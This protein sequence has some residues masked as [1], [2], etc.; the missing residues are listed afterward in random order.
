MIVA[1]AGHVDHGKTTLVRALTGVDT[2]RLPEE[3]ARGMSIDLG[4]A[5]ADLGGDGTGRLRRRARPR[6]LPP[7]HAGR[8]GRPSTS[9][10]WWSRPTTASMPQTREHLAILDL[11]GVRARRRG[12]DQDRPGRGCARARRYTRHRGAAGADRPARRADRSGVAH[13]RRRHRCAARG[14]WARRSRAGGRAPQQGNFRLAV[15][16]SFTLPGAGLVVT[17]AVLSGRRRVGDACCCRRPAPR[18]GCAASM[19]RTGRSEQAEAGMR[20]ALNLAG[21]PE[22]RRGRARRLGRRRR[23]ACAD[24][25]A[26]TSAAPAGGRRAGRWRTGRRC[27]C[28]WAPPTW[29]PTSR[30]CRT[31]RWRRGRGATRNWCSSGR[32]ARCTATASC[33]A[34]RRA[35]A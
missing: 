11:L 3:K 9:R 12:A 25:R 15:D 24:A 8:R 10:C 4:F 19:R 6:A 33:C 20:C 16:R 34:R 28:T 26:S 30:C 31:A 32:S 17:G 22:A 5:Y 35:S 7:Q 29:A 21:R 14:T 1:T 13:R 18:C 27:S 2:D 23:R